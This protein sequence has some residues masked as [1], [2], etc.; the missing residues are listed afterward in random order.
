MD[1]EFFTERH[2]DNQ[3]RR[4]QDDTGKESQWSKRYPII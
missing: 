3:I 1:E 2:Q 4:K